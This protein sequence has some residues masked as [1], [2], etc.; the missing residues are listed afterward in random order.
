MSEHWMLSFR[1]SG[2][3]K[4]QPR[5]RA[6]ARGGF[7]RVYNPDTADAWKAAVQQAGSSKCPKQPF[8]DALA[9]RIV[10]YMPRPQR[11]MRKA[12]PNGLMPFTSKPDIDNLA[13]STLDAMTSAG[14]W[15]DDAQI[16]HLHCTKIYHRKADEAG[17]IIEVMPFDLLHAEER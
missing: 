16:V 7:A 12:D 15:I 3:P 6:V 4:A 11:L 5:P 2:E 14:W 13:K 9:V 1:V 17:A 8:T 10:F